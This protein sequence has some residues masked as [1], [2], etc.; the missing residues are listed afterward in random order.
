M[1]RG[2]WAKYDRSI[3]VWMKITT[4]LMKWSSQALAV[5]LLLLQ[6][7]TTQCA[8]SLRHSASWCSTRKLGPAVFP[9]CFAYCCHSSKCHWIISLCIFV[10]L[11]DHFG[12]VFVQEIVSKYFTQKNLIG[13][14]VQDNLNVNSSMSPVINHCNWENK[15]LY[16]LLLCNSTL[17]LKFSTRIEYIF[18]VPDGGQFI[19]MSSSWDKLTDKKNLCCNVVSV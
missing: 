7:P 17:V 10:Y 18:A 8:F 9:C 11:K 4:P 12:F 16:L 19:R 5:V 1:G 2:P 6:E 13:N 15:C 3:T 14:L